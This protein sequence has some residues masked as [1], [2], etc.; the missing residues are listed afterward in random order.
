MLPC[1]GL[2]D[3]YLERGERLV[4]EVSND[5]GLVPVAEPVERGHGPVTIADRERVDILRPWSASWYSSASRILRRSLDVS[6][7]VEHERESVYRAS[8]GPAVEDRAS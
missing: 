1:A 4:L 2:S 5:A 7:A 3:A 6:V 8:V